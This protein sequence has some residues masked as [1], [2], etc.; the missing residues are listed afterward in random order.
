M[1][2]KKKNIEIEI[3][4]QLEKTKKLLDFLQ[5]KAKFVGE[6]RQ[7]D[8]YFTPVHRN[9]L[10]THPVNEWLRLRDSSGK[11]SINSKN[12]YREKDGRTHHCDEFET[13]VENMEQMENIFR[14]INIKP[15]V[16]VDKVRR[17][18]RYKNY[19]VAVD[20]VKGLGDFVEI[21]FKGNTNK[22]PSEIT[23]EM[24][25]FLKNLDCGKIT[26]DY[27]GYPFALLFPKEVNKEEC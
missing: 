8:K 26:R 20:L 14:V 7:I 16:T 27:V 21:E 22:K 25:V 18:W 5:K 9:Y 3:K 6:S 15:I 24:I 2:A 4:V 23:A 13:P 17:A 19:E 12:W 1:K 10:K 11:H